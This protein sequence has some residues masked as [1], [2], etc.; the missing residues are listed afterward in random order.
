MRW[1]RRRRAL[2]CQQA[3]ELMTDYLE[4]AMEPKD[5][6]RFEQ[7]LRDALAGLAGAQRVADE[8]DQLFLDGH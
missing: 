4:G 2:V 1:F 5:R 7:H 3:V 6:A 8:L